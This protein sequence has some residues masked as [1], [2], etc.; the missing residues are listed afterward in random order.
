MVVEVRRKVLLLLCIH[1][2]SPLSHSV[3]KTGNRRYSIREQTRL[4]PK[5]E[6]RPEPKPGRRK[7]RLKYMYYYY[8]F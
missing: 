8:I 2:I 1:C 6:P 5:L 3:A 7:Y 4:E